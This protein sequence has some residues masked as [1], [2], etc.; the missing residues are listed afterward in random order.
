L[1]SLTETTNHNPHSV[2]S[3]LTPSLSTVQL[4]LY[5]LPAAAIGYT[6]LLIST[7]VLK[8]STDVLLI[9]PA[10]MGAIFGLARIWDAVTDP[11]VGYLSDRTS[12]RLGRRRGW[13]AWSI[14]PAAAF[15]IMLFASPTGMST[16]LTA[17]WIGVA[18][19]GFYTAMTAISVPHYSLG[20]EFTKDSYTRN[21]LFGMRHAMIGVGAIL[22]LLTMSWLTGIDQQN[23]DLLRTASLQSAAAAAV[24]CVLGVLATAFLFRENQSTEQSLTQ[25]PPQNESIYAASRQIVQNKHARLLLSVHFIESIGAGALS[26]VALFV[27]QYVIGDIGI[28]PV[29]I[30]CYLIMSTISIP[31]WVRLSRRFEKVTL[32]IATMAIAAVSYGGLFLLVFMDQGFMQTGVLIILSVISGAMSGCGHT[33]GPSILSDII[34]EDDRDTGKRKEGAF[35]A[36]YNLAHKSA[37]GVTVMI[38]GVVLS[39]VGFMP[40][41]EQT[42]TVQIALCGILGLLPFICFAIGAFMFQRFDLRTEQHAAIVRQLELRAGAHA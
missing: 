19:F 1:T 26:A 34:D 18:I 30:I 20:A 12:S 27:A 5:G 33:I 13:L 21:K 38:T 31:L 37:H 14:T 15:Y 39:A 7:Y 25:R 36:L 3:S 8:Y 17:I 9:A 28:A 35:F 2:E 22:A 32:W 29:T 10:I 24:L 4:A 23:T 11:V 41:V 42:F 6:F 40:N 16:T